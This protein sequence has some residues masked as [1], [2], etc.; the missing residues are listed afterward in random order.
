MGDQS[1]AFWAAV[2]TV[3]E[4]LRHEERNDAARPE[5]EKEEDGADN[6]SS[7]TVED[8]HL[9]H[10]LLFALWTLCF[11]WLKLCRNFRANMTE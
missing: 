10:L 11:K 5:T 7:V 9:R 1:E 3:S 4:E 6:V 8:T 2:L